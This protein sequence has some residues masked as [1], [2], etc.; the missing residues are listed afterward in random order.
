MRADKRNASWPS[1]CGT[2]EALF[3]R[4]TP[5]EF[6]ASSPSMNGTKQVSASVKIARTEE[7][8]SRLVSPARDLSSK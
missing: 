6:E 1:K 4:H 7:T 8:K 2:E 3:Y 5:Y